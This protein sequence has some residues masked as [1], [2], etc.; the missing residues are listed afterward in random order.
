MT[1]DIPTRASVPTLIAIAAFGIAGIAGLAA[2]NKTPTP[3]PKAAPVPTAPL[4]VANEDVMTIRNNQLA[5][6]PSITGSILASASLP[7]ATSP[8]HDDEP[9]FRSF[10]CVADRG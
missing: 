8:S 6:G 2:C 10:A 4:L 9:A 7:H 1:R 3:T 5:S